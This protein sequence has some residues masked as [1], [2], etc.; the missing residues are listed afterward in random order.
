MWAFFLA[1]LFFAFSWSGN[2]FAFA[3][4]DTLRKDKN[5]VRLAVMG[6]VN[7]TGSKNY[8]Y[9]SVS[10][11]E[12]IKKNVKKKFNYRKSSQIKNENTLKKILKSKGKKRINLTLSDIRDLSEEQDL[13]A[14]IYGDFNV[15]HRKRKTDLVVIQSKLYLRFFDKLI[16]LK[17][18]Q[19]SLDSTVF[20]VTEEASF[21]VLNK[22][23]DL[24]KLHITFKTTV[25]VAQF[26]DDADNSDGGGKESVKTMEARKKKKKYSSK[27]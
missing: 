26:S 14:V 6:F 21:I 1:V 9:L 3:S 7:K 23:N 27:K 12:D 15:Q 2:L 20:N 16:A 13:D 11:S 17:P 10:L 4:S 18:A 22:I 25:I 8:K 24:V 19:N 5:L